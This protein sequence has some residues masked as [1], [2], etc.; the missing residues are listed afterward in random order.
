MAAHASPSSADP[1]ITEL[2]ATRDRPKRLVRDESFSKS[3]VRERSNGSRGVCGFEGIRYRGD[4]LVA[5]TI[6]LVSLMA[7][8]ATD[9]I[10]WGPGH[11]IIEVGLGCS[12]PP[13]VPV[14]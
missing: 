8:L 9:S 11:R 12:L 10:G 13:R 1:G 3:E 14:R 7:P 6:P 2:V 5:L 4:A